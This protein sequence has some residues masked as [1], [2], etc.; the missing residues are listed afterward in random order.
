MADAPASGATAPPVIAIDGPAASGK[1]TIAWNVASALGFHY[2]DSG[3]LYRL[4]ALQ[5]L[6]RSIDPTDAPRLVDLCPSLDISFRGGRAVLDGR[7]VADALRAEEVSSVASQIAVHASLRRALIE[8]QRAFRLAPGLVAEGRDMHQNLLDRPTLPAD[9]RTMATYELAQDFHRAGLLDRAE[10]LFRKL[11]GTPFEHS[12][13]SHLISIYETEKDWPKAVAATQR[14]EVLAKQPYYKEIAQYHCELAQAALLRSD[15]SAAKAE[16]E[17]ALAAHRGCARATLIQ[18]DL[19]VQNSDWLA[20]VEAWQRIESQNPAFL[21]LAA[22]RFADAYRRLRDLPTGIRRLRN[23]Q[24]QYPSLDLLNAL[25]TLVLEHEGPGAA[26][27]L[28]KDELAR[29]PTLIGLDRLLEAQLLTSPPDRRHDL[30]LVKGLVGQH[31]KRLGLYKC[32]TCG[33][34]AR[35]YYWRC[36]GCQKW[37]TY[38][39]KRTEMP[40]GYT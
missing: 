31:I 12:A 27:T 40:D 32:D 18:G 29:N 28:I 2:L 13:L 3:S 14:M 24:T 17:R 7:D 8:R 36:P 26:A 30:E 21:A 6:E 19:A 23:Y 1:G 39:P 5:A 37:E 25:F 9:K 11:D 20:A 33:F 34:R 4:I 38:S 15:T 22:D 10:A 16:I 35:Q